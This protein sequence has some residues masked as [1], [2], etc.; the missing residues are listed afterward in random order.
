[1]LWHIGLVY[2]QEL[3][4]SL[5]ICAFDTLRANNFVCIKFN[6]IKPHLKI[7]KNNSRDRHPLYVDS[8]ELQ[9]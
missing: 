6:H 9:L 2:D 8:N 3:A 1:M 4:E 7:A 5:G